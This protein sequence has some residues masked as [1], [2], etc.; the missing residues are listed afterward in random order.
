MKIAVPSESSDGLGAMRSGH[1]GHAPYMTVVTIEDNA[2]QNVESFANA[3]HDA[4]GCGGVIDYVINL[5][6]DAIIAAGM[7]RPPF[8]RFTQGGLDVFI[9]TQTP[10]VGGV[11]DRFIAGD[12]P[13]M[14]I[15]DACVH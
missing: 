13:Q 11:I 1:F 15:D 12:L 4:V 2:V 10:T 7:G 8:M 9:E 14:T 6:I 5:G 3:D